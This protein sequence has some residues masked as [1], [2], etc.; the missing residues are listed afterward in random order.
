MRLVLN[1]EES[2]A[3]RAQ[4][5]ARASNQSVEQ[6][7]TEAVKRVLPASRSRSDADPFRVPSFPG[8]LAPGIDPDPISEALHRDD[9]EHSERLRKT[10]S[11]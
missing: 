6:F 7:V 8:G 2:L 4:E 11:R 10:D 3:K 5:A 9:I 1:I